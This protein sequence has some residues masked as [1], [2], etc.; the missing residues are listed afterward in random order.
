M[1]IK[2]IVA[3]IPARS[4]SKRV[5][6]KNMRKIE[7]NSLIKKTV[8]QA[9]SSKQIKADLQIDEDIYLNLQ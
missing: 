5:I 8:L 3:L 4:G 6:D 1:E 2:E 7:G 9:K